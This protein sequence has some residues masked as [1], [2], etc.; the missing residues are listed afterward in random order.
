[1]FVTHPLF[2]QSQ[3]KHGVHVSVYIA[4]DIDSRLVIELCAPVH[5]VHHI[6][7]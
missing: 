4:L 2:A 5:H 3:K 1:M 7:L 6:A